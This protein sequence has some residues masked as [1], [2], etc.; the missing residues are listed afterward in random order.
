MVQPAFNIIDVLSAWGKT[1]PGW[2]HFLLSKLVAAD[3]LPDEALDEVFAEYLSEQHLAGPETVRATWDMALP[4]FQVGVPAVVST[5]TTMTSLSG[6][7]ALATGETLSFGPKLT[8]VY[9]PNGAGK[10]F[11]AFHARFL[12]PDRTAFVSPILVSNSSISVWKDLSSF[13]RLNFCSSDSLAQCSNHS[14]RTS[15]SASTRSRASVE[16]G[17]SLE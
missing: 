14:P 11:M 9:G 17:S 8:V 13:P 4:Q 1:L 15:D 10:P 6:V 16:P 3:G 2:Q 5:L 7:N 12:K